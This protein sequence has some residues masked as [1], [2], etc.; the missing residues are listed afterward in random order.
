MFPDSL[1][2]NSK[3]SREGEK[4]SC[5]IQSPAGP[6]KGVA[7]SCRSRPTAS[8]SPQ[9]STILPPRKRKMPM[10]ATATRRPVGGCS[11]TL[12]MVDAARD[13]TYRHLIPLSD[14]ILDRVI[15]IGEDG[16]PI[17]NGLLDVLDTTK[18]GIER[19]VVDVAG[20]EKLIRYVG[21]TR[22]EKLL[23]EAT[24]S[25]LVFFRYRRLLRRLRLILPPPLRAGGDI[26][27]LRN[28]WF[29][30]PVARGVLCE[31]S[32]PPYRTSTPRATGPQTLAKGARSLS[33]AARASASDANTP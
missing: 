15:S 26:L 21:V 8:Y 3:P 13:P 6:G 2:S 16:V 31:S 18:F 22:V 25:S 27:F 30:K 32:D 10:L 12:S 11:G 23:D 7:L 19:V 9:L 5:G 1:L 24:G 28:P 14:H 29:R 17:A 33:A 20:G 4:Q